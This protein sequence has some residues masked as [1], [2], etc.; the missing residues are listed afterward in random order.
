MTH[1]LT[2]GAG[3]DDAPPTH[4][5]RVISVV[6]ARAGVAGSPEPF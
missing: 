6:D 5:L 1:P 4:L 2:N 3:D